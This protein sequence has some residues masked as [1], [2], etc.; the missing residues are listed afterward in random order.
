MVAVASAHA[1]LALSVVVPLASL[2]AAAGV[3]AAR[4]TSGA[5]ILPGDRALVVLVT[6]IT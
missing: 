5:A 6:L 4:A 1:T 3:H 2:V